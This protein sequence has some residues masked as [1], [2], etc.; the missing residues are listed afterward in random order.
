MNMSSL[1]FS[2]LT[3]DLR[4]RI[5]A[6]KS[7]IEVMADS[8][9]TIDALKAALRKQ[10]EDSIQELDRIA[11]AAAKYGLRITKDAADAASPPPSLPNPEPVNPSNVAKE[12]TVF[13][14]GYIRHE[15]PWTD[16]I[17]E[18]VERNSL[19]VTTSELKVEILNTHLGER[20]QQTGTAF[21]GAIKKL[22]ERKKIVSHN[23]RLYTPSTLSQF[24]KVTGSQALEDNGS[25]RSSPTKDAI[26]RFLER[27]GSATAPAAEIMRMLR[28]NGKEINNA[29]LYNLL[30]KMT[31]RGELVKANGAYTLPVGR[32]SL[33]GMKDFKVEERPYDKSFGP[34]G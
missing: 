26:I 14:S 8:P 7:E 19:G 1:L 21:Y 28:Q 12:A 22:K 2:S 20:L 6:I 31:K 16:T 17:L 24:I 11:E 30:S 32:A 34:E 33:N 29:S 4:E 25:N 15:K 5:E 13:P 27:K 3:P 23:G 18:I 9:E 10:Y